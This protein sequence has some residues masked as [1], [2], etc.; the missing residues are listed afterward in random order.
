MD[1]LKEITDSLP[2]VIC[3]AGFEA[4]N[5]VLYTDNSEFFRSSESQI[6]ELVSIVKRPMCVNDKD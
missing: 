5:I 3:D 1:I 4:A 2:K 6:K